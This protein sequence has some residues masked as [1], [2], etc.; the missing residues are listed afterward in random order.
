MGAL[1]VSVYFH[2]YITN[3]AVEAHEWAPGQQCAGA[4]LERLA[5]SA[6]RVV[7]VSYGNVGWHL[8]CSQP[9]RPGMDAGEAP[10]L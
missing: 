8:V 3:T 4:Q 5:P 6:A 2:G 9:Q 10:G 7:G 1:P